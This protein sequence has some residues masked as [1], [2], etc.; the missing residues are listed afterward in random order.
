[1]FLLVSD[2]PPICLDISSVILSGG[3]LF[4]FVLLSLQEA[5]RVKMC[6]E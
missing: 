3:A 1:M 6:N 2:S 5:S 4:C